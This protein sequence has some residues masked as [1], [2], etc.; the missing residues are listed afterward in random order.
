MKRLHVHVAV[1]NLEES[2]KFYTTMFG[3]EPVK[4]KTDYAQWLLDDPRVNFA[5]SARGRAPGVD[6]MGIQVDEDSELA[7]VRDRIKQADIKTFDEGETACCYAKADKTW[8]IDPGGVAWEAYKT[9]SDVEF[10][11]KDQKLETQDESKA[12]CAPSQEKPKVS[13]GEAVA[14]KKSCC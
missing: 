8:V 3:A 11:G 5:I 7:E 1:K 9:M 10:F 12:C 4:L 2:M 6:H 14:K 13:L